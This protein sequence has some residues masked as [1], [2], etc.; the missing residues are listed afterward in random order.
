MGQ[1]AYP[2]VRHGCVP[3]FNELK[4]I[5]LPLFFCNKKVSLKKEFAGSKE[6]IH[7]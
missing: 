5:L 4:F 3:E 7:G 6:N 2:T 1:H